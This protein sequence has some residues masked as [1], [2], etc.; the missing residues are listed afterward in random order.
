MIECGSKKYKV[1]DKNVEVGDKILVYKVDG[2]V[3]DYPVLR[4]VEGLFNE[5]FSINKEIDGIGALFKD[6]PVDHYEVVEE[7]K[8][9]GTCQV[10]NKY[11]EIG[12][13]LGNLVDKKQAAYGDSITKA[14]Q[15]LRIFLQE[16]KNEDGTYTIP[17]SL[18]THIGLMVRMI[19]KQNRI[20]SNPDGDLMSE[21][22]YLDISG[23]GM[24]GSEMK[25]ESSS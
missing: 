6:S 8:G 20:F 9:E 4:I 22:P 13:N 23:Y 19:D 24:L 17:D 18:L 1:L 7:I 10:I 11:E 16:Y 2:Q 21:S 14:D 15:L 12:K 5:E 3:L 25:N